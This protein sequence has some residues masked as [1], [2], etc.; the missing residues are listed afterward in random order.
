MRRQR[1]PPARGA[2]SDCTFIFRLPVPA[3]GRP[4]RRPLPQ[5]HTQTSRRR[6]RP[7]DL[8]HQIRGD[9]SG[10]ALRSTCARRGTGR[11]PAGRRRGGSRGSPPPRRRPPDPT[12]C[13]QGGVCE[14]PT[15]RAAH[16]GR[17]RGSLWVSVSNW[18]LLSARL[19]LT[20]G[21]RGRRGSHGD[22]RGG[23]GEGGGGRAQ[24]AGCPPPP[25]SPAAPA[26]PRPCA[27]P[28]RPRTRSSG[29]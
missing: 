14:T 15:G 25:A 7:P 13:S 17:A 2:P 9:G 19:L 22:P 4:A 29:R 20:P 28:C 21:P 1:A 5:Q 26:S 23:A 27:P 6:P 16:R 24:P 18:T 10:R 11:D 12:P 3:V 8:R